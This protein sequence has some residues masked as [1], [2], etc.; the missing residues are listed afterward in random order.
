MPAGRIIKPVETEAA[1]AEAAKKQANKDYLTKS[2]LAQNTSSKWGGEGFGSTDA[3][4][5]AM[6]EILANNG[7][8]RLE[9][10]GKVPTYKPVQIMSWSLN[11][12]TVYSNPGR[13][14]Y[15][16]MPAGMGYDESGNYGMQYSNRYL[17][18][19][20]T[21]QIQPTQYGIRA[22]DPEYGDVVVPVPNNKIQTVNGVQSYQDGEVWGNKATGKPIPAN[23]S[24]AGENI[25]GGTF[26]GKDKTSFGV[27]LNEVGMPIFYTQYGGSTSDWG[28]ISPILSFASMIPGVGPFAAAINAVG[29][30][31]HGNTTGAVLSALSAA[32]GFGA[33]YG[34][35]DPSS[36]NYINSMDAASDAA[37]GVTASTGTSLA[38]FF[39]ENAGTIKTASQA[40]QVL[41]AI[42]KK[43][44]SGIINGLTNLAP[45]IGVTIPSDIMAPVAYAA[46]ASAISKGDFAGALAAAGPLINNPALK[47]NLVMAE[48]A[49][50]LVNA[51][52]SENPAAILSSSMGF[53]KQANLG[54]T[55][56]KDLASSFGVNLSDEDLVAFDQY[57]A[58]SKEFDA[59]TKGLVKS[60]EDN[61]VAADKADTSASEAAKLYED[62]FGK[63]PEN[64]GELARFIGRPEADVKA[65]LDTEFGDLQT[66]IT[67]ASALDYEFG[68][69]QG[70]ID[71]NASAKDK[72]AF[73]EAYNGARNLAELEGKDP[74]TAT[75]SWTNPK[76]GET[77]VYKAISD[78]EVKAQAAADQARIDL[79][80]AYPE[81]GNRSGRPAG[82]ENVYI[83][84]KTGNVVNDDRVYD[85]LG[86]VVS[87]SLELADNDTTVA[88]LQT[89]VGSAI[90][91][92]LDVGSGLIKGGAG[93]LEAAGTVYGLLGGDMDNAAVKTGAQVKAAVDSMRSNEFKENQKLMNDAIKKAG[94]ESQWL[95]AYE[96]LKQYGTSPIQAATFIAEQGASLLIG[97]GAT[98]VARG[99]GAGLTIAETSALAANALIQGGS[100]A[101]ETYDE[102]KKQGATEDEAKNAA[103][104]SGGVASVV[105]A[106]ANKYIPGAM[107]NE[108]IFAAKA[109]I[110]TSLKTAVKGEMSAELIEE[111]AGKIASN[112]ATGKPWS[113]ELGATAVQAL[114]GS[115]VVTGLTHTNQGPLDPV[116]STAPTPFDNVTADQIDGVMKGFADKNYTPTTEELIDVLQDAPDASG[117]DLK[118]FASEYAQSAQDST[119]AKEDPLQFLK[120]AGLDDNYERALQEDPVAAQEFLTQLQAGNIKDAVGAL[121][122][123]YSD[124][125]AADAQTAEAERIRNE[126]A[127]T[128]P[129]T[130]PVDPVTT[131]PTEPVVTPPTEP[132]TPP[133]EPV[134]TPPVDP[135]LEKVLEGGDPVTEEDLNDIVNPT[136]PVTPPV[137][138][139]VEP[140]VTPGTE[141]T[142][143]TNT[144]TGA[145]TGTGGAQT[146][147]NQTGVDLS[148]VQQQVADVQKNLSAEIQAAKDIG[149]EGDAALQAGL[150]SLAQKMGV[151]QAALLSQL[152]ATAEGLKTQF[153]SDLAASQ[154]A[155]AAE[156][157][158]TKTALEAAIAEA[159]ASGLEGDAALK[160]AIDAVAASQ[161]TNAANLLSKLGTTEANL[162]SEFAAGLAGVT[163]DIDATRTAL[164]E[165]IKA[166]QDIGL[167]GDAA[168][169]A[170]IDSVAATQQTDA[171]SLLAKLGTTEAAL[172]TDMASGLANV[173]ASVADTR[174]ALEAAIAEA[175]AAGLSGDQA[176]QSAISK[177]AADQKTNAADLFSKLGTTESGLRNEFAAGLAGVSTEIAD[178]RK[179][180]ED[181]IQAAKDIGLEGD[182]ALQAGIDSVA[183]QLGTTK[184]TLLSQLNTTEAA[185]RTEFTSGITGLQGQM[186]AQY[187]SLTDAQKATADALFEQGQTL[188]QAI[189]A[190]KAE[191]TGQISELEA[192]T[193]AQYETL[194]AAQKT[195]ADALVAQGK[196]LQD[197]IAAA[198]T[199]T[200]GQ[201][202][203]VETR[204]TDA[205]AAAEAMGL[206]RDQA[207]T[208]AVDSVASELGTTKAALLAQMGTTEA[209]LR[210]DFASGISGLEA[211]TKAQYDALTA[212]QKATADALTAQGTTLADAI[213][214]AKAETTGQIGA[215]TADVQAKY[216]ALTAEQKTLAN[217]IAQQGVDLNTAIEQAKTQTQQ[218]ITDLGVQVDARINELMQQGQTY[219]QATQNAFAEV[220]AKNQEL[221]GLIGTQGRSANQS[222]IDALTQMLGGQRSM[223]LNYDVTGDKQITQADVDFLTS[224]V[225]GTNTDWAAPEKSPW[226]A[227]GLYGQIQANELQRR[228]DLADAAAAAEAQRQADAE[229]A[230][231]AGL[232]GQIKTGAEQGRQQLQ[233]IQQQ[234]PQALRQSQEVSTPIYGQMGPY[235]DIG[236]DLDFDF[237]KP[238]QEKQAGTKQQQPTKIASGGY[239]DDLLAGDMTVDELLNLLR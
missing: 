150:D 161:N 162:K 219:Q 63:P 174:I 56:Y 99:L 2:I 164:T 198:K 23:Y 35:I 75:F 3:N 61:V 178:T 69:Y 233:N 57:P 96:T 10:F 113:S 122:T 40:V 43:D 16:S 112:I 218:Q 116:Q 130:P 144:D 26:A 171:A 212:A 124:Q 82:A 132:V 18:A 176:L 49:N 44:L 216:D 84:T 29:N 119:A 73:G 166:A 135:E 64:T 175:R 17:S 60:Y 215:L 192:A 172:R 221:S 223:D 117:A 110:G 101:K 211:Q 194:T 209:A 77:G 14:Y 202:A 142:P 147:S 137:T 224:V 94:G 156:I 201:I 80:P 210:A 148:G 4:A 27:H 90:R 28:Q 19:E 67:K 55:S 187:D 1:K 81:G 97:G 182:A 195:T 58:D 208:A 71:K 42:D 92:A 103:R 76:T 237:F 141:T 206:T 105:S 39:A 236:S 160:S 9:D 213:A 5:Y 217:Q 74:K 68:D 238:S 25:W 13:G 53:A 207:I 179:A 120:D 129:V 102:L 123:T 38:N 87:G 180:L 12:Q 181:A 52:K 153:A 106:L 115:G 32:G 30:A 128:P 151:D 127:I 230:R 7:I 54:K 165:A 131:P 89:A 154:T 108:Q 33:E 235:L 21:K 177:V 204:L 114:I 143:N 140:V 159:K 125:A 205:I 146:G 214:A 145:N 45:Q 50:A 95:A 136:T 41:N 227:T 222:D 24:G 185:L 126:A 62:V 118:N 46:T 234:L 139:P 66:A 47:Q 6:A 163:S 173:T 199:E 72:I 34:T 31:Y 191:T 107:S 158:S 232:R 170:A 157:A 184:E 37:L 88:A 196:T 70:A 193:K 134:V 36:A 121:N 20:Q 79:M 200:A 225:R 197:A 48:K 149:L 65:E 228:K 22:Y 93:V 8:T 85:A 51:I 229:E 220:N 152:G 111:T 167:Q 100:V 138:P 15:M 78:A 186:K 188:E 133:V 183:A 203:G 11:G 231:K 226:A 104:A 239:I 83:D 59:E 189:A 155:T 109:A 98:L 169:K 168:L 86:N 91:T 190:A